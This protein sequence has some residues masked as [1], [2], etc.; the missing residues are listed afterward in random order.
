MQFRQTPIHVTLSGDRLTLASHPEGA[1]HPVRAGV[2]GDVRD[3]CPGDRAIFEF[4]Q[5]AAPPGP[6]AHN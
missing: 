2:R 6:R 1:A 4:G 5:D 3:L